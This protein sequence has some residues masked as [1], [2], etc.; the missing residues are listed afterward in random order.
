LDEKVV[1]HRVGGG[2]ATRFIAPL[3]GGAG[4]Q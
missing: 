3:A 4:T 1:L 2:G